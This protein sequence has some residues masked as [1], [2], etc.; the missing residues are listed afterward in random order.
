M[1]R[2]IPNR[3]FVEWQAYEELEPFG[4][5]R[6]DIRA[7][8]IERSLWNLWA[9]PK[10]GGWELYRFLLPLGDQLEPYKRTK[11][12]TEAEAKEA[13]WRRNKALLW[14]IA[15]AWAGPAVSKDPI[16]GDDLLK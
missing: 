3:L 16:T 6:A 4:E 11:I 5:E 15:H 10:E 2:A 7:A 12:L 14:G 13:Q 8:A 1:L 9:R